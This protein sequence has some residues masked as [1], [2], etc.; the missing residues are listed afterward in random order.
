MITKAENRFVIAI[1]TITTI[2]ITVL[3]I[4]AIIITVVPIIAFVTVVIR[5][6]IPRC[7]FAGVGFFGLGRCSRLGLC[8]G[9][10]GLCGLCLWGWCI[11][12]GV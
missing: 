6:C 10:C 3:T 7:R 5:S 11:R 8:G 2:V 9:R 4:V 12:L 1:I